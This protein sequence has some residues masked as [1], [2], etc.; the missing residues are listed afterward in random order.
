MTVMGTT[1]TE[2]KEAGQAIIAAFE[3]LKDLSDKVELGEY[4]GFPMTLWVSDSGLSPKLQITLKQHL[5]PARQLL[6][7]RNFVPVL[8]QGK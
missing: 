4:R 2:K 1:Y 8:G 3:S 5:Y 7:C 6:D